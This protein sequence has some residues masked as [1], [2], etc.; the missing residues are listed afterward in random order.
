MCLCKKSTNK[1]K[2]CKL[3]YIIY[4]CTKN[5]SFTNVIKASNNNK[6]KARICNARTF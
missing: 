3:E 2:E 5:T 6:E 1:K 4:C